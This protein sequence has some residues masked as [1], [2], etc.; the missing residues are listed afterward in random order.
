[1]QDQN[2]SSFN[3]RIYRVSYT[4]QS[5]FNCKEQQVSPL[6]LDRDIH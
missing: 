2:C 4:I 5:I 3:L 1:M 6:D